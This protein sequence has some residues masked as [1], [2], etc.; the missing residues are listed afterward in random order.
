MFVASLNP[1][2]KPVL[3][4]PANLV[5]STTDSPLFL[6][7]SVVALEYGYENMLALSEK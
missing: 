2:K 6:P 1:Y 4:K 7:S 5:V 3:F